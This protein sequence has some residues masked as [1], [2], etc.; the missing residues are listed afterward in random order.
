[1]ASSESCCPNAYN[2]DVKNFLPSGRRVASILITAMV[3]QRNLFSKSNR[4][5]TRKILAGSEWEYAKEAD[6]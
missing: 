4:I 2:K 6:M 1:M 5:A 3:N